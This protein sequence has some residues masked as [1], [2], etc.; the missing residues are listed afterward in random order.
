[1]K[2]SL[3][4]LCVIM[5]SLVAHAKVEHLLPVPKDL[6]LKSGKPFALGRNVCIQ[7]PT[8]SGL[9]REV[10][11]DNGCGESLSGTPVVVTIVPEITGAYDY[12]LPGYENEA[13]CIDVASDR[14]D[15]TAVTPVGVIR[16]A[17][18]LAQLAEGWDGS[19]AI[20]MREDYGLS[21]VQVARLYARCGPFICK[22]GRAY[23]SNEAVGK[24]QGQYIPLAYDRKSGMEI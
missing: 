7:D 5:V 23:A 12:N 22:C 9:L 1:M 17:Q 2:K 14:I 15:I 21:V 18:T 11:A 24:I 10:F 13:Y 16:A 3:V 20:E 8:G 6:E 4:L 19:S